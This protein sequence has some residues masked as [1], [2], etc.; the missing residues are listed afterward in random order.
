[1]PP[2]GT[3]RKLLMMCL[4]EHLLED[5]GRGARLGVAELVVFIQALRIAHH[6]NAMM[7]DVYFRTLFNAPYFLLI[8]WLT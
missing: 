2:P 4:F 8:Q 5:V 1:M 7:T 3:W 6:C